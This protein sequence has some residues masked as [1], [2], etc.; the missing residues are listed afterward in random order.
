MHLMIESVDL[1]VIVREVVSRHAPEL[2][3]AHSIVQ[4][5]GDAVLFGRWDR[6][7]L[8]Q[9]VDNLVSNAIKFGKGRPIEVTLAQE[10]DTA[11]LHVTDRGIG[12]PEDKLA[13]IFEPFERA[14]P[15]RHYG[16]L[17]LGL[18]IVRAIVARLGGRISVRSTAETGTTF[19]VEL[20]REVTQ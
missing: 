17:G 5:L 13:T 18:Y 6:T 8:E 4:M 14:V 20:P 2:E 7:R 15:D 3:R 11:I 10:G 9:V 19:T 1:A 12:I 16:G